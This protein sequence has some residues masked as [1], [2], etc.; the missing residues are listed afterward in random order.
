ML[1]SVRGNGVEPDRLLEM[2]ECV[3]EEQPEKKL[4]AMGWWALSWFSSQG[5]QA[6]ARCADLP[7]D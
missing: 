3:E 5:V 1:R 7:Q 4:G 6:S 2:R